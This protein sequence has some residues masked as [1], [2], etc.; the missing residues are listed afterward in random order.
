MREIAGGDTLAKGAA[1]RLRYYIHDH[2][3]MFRLQLLGALTLRDLP[4]L[5]G[6]WKTAESSISGRSIQ[7]DMRLLTT[8]DEAGE[9]WLASMSQISRVTFVASSQSAA[10][11]PTGSHLNVE[12]SEPGRI[13]AQLQKLIAAVRAGAAASQGGQTQAHGLPLM[14]SAETEVSPS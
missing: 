14:K 5:Q 3:G 12:S 8:V 10:L 6:C 9:E 7:I 1:T 2:A 13:G 11:V 4:E